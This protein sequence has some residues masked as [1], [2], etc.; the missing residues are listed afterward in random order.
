MFARFGFV[1][2]SAIWSF[3]RVKVSMLRP[4]I[5][6]HNERL[7]AQQGSD[8]AEPRTQGQFRREAE[9]RMLEYIQGMVVY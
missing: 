2:N 3:K 9:A 4:L 8:S 7:E 5:H 6:S 1:R